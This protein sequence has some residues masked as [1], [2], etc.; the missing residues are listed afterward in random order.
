MMWDM[1]QGFSAEMSVVPTQVSGTL[2][3]FHR[4]RVSFLCRQGQQNLENTDPHDVCRPT[5][6]WFPQNSEALGG[7]PGSQSDQPPI[8]APNPPYLPGSFQGL[9]ACSSSATSNSSAPSHPGVFP[10]RL[11]S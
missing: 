10:A 11:E 1:G 4:L 7:V 8:E 6:G 2:V 9:I 5:R 3:S